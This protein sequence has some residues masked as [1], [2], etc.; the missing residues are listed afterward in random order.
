MTETPPALLL[1]EEGGGDMARNR[2]Y[3]FDGLGPW[4]HLLWKL[5]IMC[6]GRGP[7]IT[8]V[9]IGIIGP[10]LA[11]L[12]DVVGWKAV[13]GSIFLGTYLHTIRTNERKNKNKCFEDWPKM[14][15][16]T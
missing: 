9:G 10:P 5:E 8:T 1:G 15:T 6:R 12:A 4:Y 3:N 16:L 2:S 7:C 11:P 14:R 13:P